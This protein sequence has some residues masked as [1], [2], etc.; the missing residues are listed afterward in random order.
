MGFADQ[1]VTSDVARFQ[2]T[3]DILRLHPELRLAGPTWGWLE[4]AYRSM[5]R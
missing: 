2:R 5:E 1:I 4:A 3:Q